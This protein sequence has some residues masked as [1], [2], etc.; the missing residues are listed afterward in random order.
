MSWLRDLSAVCLVIAVVEAVFQTYF[1]GLVAANWS[2]SDASSTAWAAM[3]M[4]RWLSN[5][6]S[7]LLAAIVFALLDM[8]ADKERIK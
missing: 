4:Q 3:Y 8:G 7:P 1:G 5:V 6:I 2:I